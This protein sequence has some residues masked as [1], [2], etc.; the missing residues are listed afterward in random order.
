MVSIRQ[1][2]YESKLL[3]ASNKK[4][5][6]N[7]VDLMAVL[8]MPWILVLLAPRILQPHRQVKH[9][10]ARPVVF[11]IRHKVAMPLKLKLVIRLR[12]RQ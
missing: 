8:L 4:H 11:A 2:F 3:L 1:R 7:H 12:I 5:I 6:T 10:L 9:R